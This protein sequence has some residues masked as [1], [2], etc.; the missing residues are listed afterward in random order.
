MS[1]THSI[2]WIAVVPT[3]LLATVVGA[4]ALAGDVSVPHAFSPGQVADANQVNECF[5][6]LAAEIN[7]NHARLS[8]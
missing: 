3:L 5:A 2:T 8:V 7:D 4:V 1:R 6:K